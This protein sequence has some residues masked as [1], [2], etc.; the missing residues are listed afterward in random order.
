MRSLNVA[1]S[2]FAAGRAQGRLTKYLDHECNWLGMNWRSRRGLVERRYR[3]ESAPFWSGWTPDSVA[4]GD[5]EIEQAETGDQA[6]HGSISDK[7]LERRRRGE[8]RVVVPGGRIPGSAADQQPQIH[9]DDNPQEALSL[10]QPVGDAVRGW[11]GWRCL[12]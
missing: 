2:W 3:S 12:Y 1:E 8:E 7:S 6:A 5:P 9:A 11:A 4:D 10:L